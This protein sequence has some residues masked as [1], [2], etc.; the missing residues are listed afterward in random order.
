[1]PDQVDDALI[2]I[3]FVGSGDRHDRVRTKLTRALDLPSAEHAHAERD[4]ATLTA[5]VTA[6]GG[7]LNIQLLLHFLLSATQLMRVRAQSKLATLRG[8][9]LESCSS[10][11]QNPNGTGKNQFNAIQ[12]A[13]R[14]LNG[15]DDPDHVRVVQI[16]TG[17]L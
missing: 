1:M 10:R 15:N 13:V 14:N 4:D 16:A 17:A 2:Q 11:H 8:R 5:R 12:S 3:V 6:P 7:G 9:K